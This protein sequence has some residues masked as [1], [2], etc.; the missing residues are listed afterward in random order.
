MLSSHH[1]LVPVTQQSPGS[2][3]REG[4]GAGQAHRGA[5]RAHHRQGL[6]A[7]LRRS[8]RSHPPPVAGSQPLC[9]HT[10]QR[11]GLGLSEGPQCAKP[12]Y[13]RPTAPSRPCRLHSTTLRAHTDAWARGRWGSP[14][15]Q[16]LPGHAS[17]QLSDPGPHQRAAGTGPLTAPVGFSV[18]APREMVPSI[19]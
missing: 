4:E 19:A 17:H 1:R 10:S 12:A 11:K 14:P 18:G 2:Q 5:G 13:Y 9:S 7:G 16:V 6:D 8:T 15:K 3:E